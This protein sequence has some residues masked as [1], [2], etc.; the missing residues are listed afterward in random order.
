MGGVFGGWFE[1]NFPSFFLFASFHATAIFVKLFPAALT[2]SCLHEMVIASEDL[3]I[4]STST[5]EGNNFQGHIYRCE[6]NMG[7]RILNVKF[8]TRLAWAL[9]TTLV[10]VLL[11]VV[12]G[13]KQV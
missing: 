5:E 8:T 1:G 13:A 3:C 10:T 7:Y 4:S 6:K 12:R 11:T 9:L 2:S